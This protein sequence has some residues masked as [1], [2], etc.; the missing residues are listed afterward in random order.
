MIPYP[1]NAVRTG[2]LGAGP[3][4]IKEREQRKANAVKLKKEK[5]EKL[6][7]Y[8]RVYPIAAPS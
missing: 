6:T 2:G 3:H 1:S 4:E 8:P 7:L 5:K